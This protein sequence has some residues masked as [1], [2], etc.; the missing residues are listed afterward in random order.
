MIS[1]ELDL[2]S[3]AGSSVSEYIIARFYSKINEPQ[4]NGAKKGKRALSNL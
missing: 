4:Q 2:D 1:P 3:D